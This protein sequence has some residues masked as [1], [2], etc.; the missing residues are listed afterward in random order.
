MEYSKNSVNDPFL[1]LESSWRIPAWD[2]VKEALTN[3][4]YNCAKEIT[5]KV[6]LKQSLQ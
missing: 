1:L 4:E 2:S 6:S 3:I 5:W